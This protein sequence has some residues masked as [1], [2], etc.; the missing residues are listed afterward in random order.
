[1]RGKGIN[2][3]TG[4]YTDPRGSR[5]QFSPDIVA[6][7][8]RVIAREL[9]CTAVR[10]SGGRPDRLSVA[11]EAAAAAGLEVWFSPFP[12]DLT[13]GQMAPLLAECADRAEHLRRTGARV[14]LVTGCELSLFAVGF[15]PGASFV[16]RI[17]GLQAPGPALY[18]AFGS[19]T[20]R[21]N[22]FLAETLEAARGRFS[23]P[24]SYASG[25]WE[26]VDWTRFD[27]VASDAYRDEGNAATFRDEV[28]KLSRHGKPVAVTEFGCCPY[29]GAAAKGGTGWAIVDFS[30]DPLRLDGDYVRDEGEQVRY[31]QEVSRVFR[32]EGV[33]LAF[34]YTF[35]GYYLQRSAD[36]RLDVDLASYGVVSM[37]PGE[38]GSG[39]R[40]LGWTPRLVFDALASA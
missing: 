26:Q 14:V 36:P 2:Y 19:L 37:E 39:R 10:I 25:L 8:M 12:I 40:S 34:W 16:D 28:R 11:A 30:A 21:L 22:A 7:E 31:L 3:D 20:A 6:A 32:E 29:A 9:G 35:A 38:P 17:T 4:F 5:P 33:D 23:G 27:I 1:V 24:V 13:V 18:E 15:L